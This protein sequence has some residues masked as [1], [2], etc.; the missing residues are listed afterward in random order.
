MLRPG[1]GRAGGVRVEG[2]CQVDLAA[3]RPAKPIPGKCITTVCGPGVL[4]LS[5]MQAATPARIAGQFT[6]KSP[7]APTNGTFM[8]ANGSGLHDKT[9]ANSMRYPFIAFLRLVVCPLNDKS[10]VIAGWR[11]HRQ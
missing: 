8:P 2:A 11:N 3:Y 1:S 10:V 9:A 5:P 7:L 4:Y 6:I